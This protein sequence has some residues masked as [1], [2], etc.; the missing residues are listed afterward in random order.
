MVKDRGF[1]LLSETRK[2]CPLLPLQFNF[3]LKFPNQSSL[4]RKRK[5]CV[6]GVEDLRYQYYPKWSTASVSLLKSQW[7][8]LWNRKIHPKIHEESQ[9]IPNSQNNLEEKEQNWRTNTS[10]F[11]S[12]YCPFALAMTF[13]SDIEFKLWEQ[14]FVLSLI[15]GKLYSVFHY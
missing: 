7:C 15:L 13:N 8:F 11:F 6:Y 1:P 4:A 14:T 5:A 12:F 10:I 2:G 3:V 9:G